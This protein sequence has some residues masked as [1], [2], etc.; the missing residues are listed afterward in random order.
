MDLK[1]A[2][3]AEQICDSLDFQVDRQSES[4]ILWII[5]NLRLRA[6]IH[7]SREKS[8]S[9][10]RTAGSIQ[11]REREGGQVQSRVEQRQVCQEF[12]VQRA[13]LQRQEACG[14]DR[15]PRGKTRQRE[16]QGKEQGKAWQDSTSLVQTKK[17]PRGKW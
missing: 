4:T 17:K 3:P 1:S 11:G 5:I 16:E 10:Q 8:P 9:R 6:R 14:K 2:R 15:I 12:S 13:S 7:L